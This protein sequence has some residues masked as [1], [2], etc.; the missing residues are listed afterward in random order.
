V[1]RHKHARITGIVLVL[2]LASLMVGLCVWD[3]GKEDSADTASGEV[4][5]LF[6][7]DTA[8]IFYTMDGEYDVPVGEFLLYATDVVE[9]Y[10]LQYG[11]DFWDG[12]DEDMYGNEDTYKN[13]AFKDTLEQIRLVKAVCLAADSAG[14]AL[15]G[16][17]EAALEEGISSYWE[18]LSDAFSENGVEDPLVTEDMVRTYMQESYMAQKYYTTELSGIEDESE[19]EDR[20]QEILAAYCPSFVYDSDINWDLLDQLS[21]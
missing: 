14:E 3:Y 7:E 4:Y 12:T 19:L 6:P 9:G 18:S 15:S 8:A 20:L 21:L 11:E 10:T 17:E 1:E 5:Y 13:L 16:E 2:A